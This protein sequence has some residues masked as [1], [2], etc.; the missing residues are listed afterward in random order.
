MR[1][2]VI[3]LTIALTAASVLQACGHD[4]PGGRRGP[5]GGFGG[6]GG[7]VAAQEPS[8]EIQ[9]RRFD[10]D[11]DGGITRDE[12]DKVIKAD[13][14]VCDANGD[15]ELGA[16]E[17]R[18]SND[19]LLVDRK[20]SPIID[21]NG[22]GH[23]AIDEFAAQWRA[24]FEK[25]DAD[26]DGIVTADELARPARGRPPGGRGGQG[27][28]GGPGGPGGQRGPGGPGRGGPPRGGN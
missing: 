13:F 22:D 20:T 2:K 23:V 15:G 11:A 8:R 19:R 1:H 5:P 16:A 4:S 27:G 7:P 14:A 18:A 6:P 9:L 12:F 3:A 17:T 21:W 26:R 10:A 28:Q 25:A 24:L